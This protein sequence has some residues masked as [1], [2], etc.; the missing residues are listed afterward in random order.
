MA[1]PAGS[2][3]AAARRAAVLHCCRG[4]RRAPAGVCAPVLGPSSCARRDTFSA[5][6]SSYERAAS[7]VGR[8]ADAAAPTASEYFKYVSIDATTTRASTVTRS[9]PTSES[10]TQ[11]SMTMPL[12]RTRSRTSTTLL[13]AEV[14][15][16]AIRGLFRGIAAVDGRF[17]WADRTYTWREVQTENFFLPWHHRG[18]IRGQIR[19]RRPSL[20]YTRRAIAPN[21]RVGKDFSCLLVPRP[22]A[23]VLVGPS[24]G[25]QPLAGPKRCPRGRRRRQ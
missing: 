1:Y 25:S 2:I 4:R 10:R 21:R 13:P 17:R 9:I 23:I 20:T 18:E 14:R 11:A 6:I 16:T 24:D 19:Q 7:R 5:A 8:A 15:S 22:R 3:R 12:S